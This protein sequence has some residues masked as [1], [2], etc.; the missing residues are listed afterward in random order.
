LP[1]KFS[2]TAASMKRSFEPRHYWHSSRARRDRDRI[3]AEHQRGERLTRCGRLNG[4]ARVGYG[5]LERTVLFKR[6]H[7]TAGGARRLSFLYVNVTNRSVPNSLLGA[8]EGTARRPVITARATMVMAVIGTPIV[9]GF[10]HSIEV[11][12]CW[13]GRCSCCG[14]LFIVRSSQSGEQH[15]SMT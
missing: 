11:H 14:R 3:F 9:T 8:L 1:Q 6:V 10:A 4:C 7:A 5:W 15:R 2:L 13:N 12:G